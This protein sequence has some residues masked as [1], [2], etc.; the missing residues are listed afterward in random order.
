MRSQHQLC[1]Q[2][3]CVKV[4]LFFSLPFLCQF[5]F[6]KRYLNIDR[7][8]HAD[9]ESTF[10]PDPEL[11]FF[12]SCALHTF[13]PLWHPASV[14]GDQNEKQSKKGGEG[15][16]FRGTGGAVENRVGYASKTNR[17]ETAGQCCNNGV[18][19]SC[20]GYLATGA[21]CCQS[22]SNQNWAQERHRETAG[23]ALRGSDS[24]IVT[25]VAWRFT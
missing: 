5:H 4:N 21:T 8:G 19:L 25:N 2:C 15:E 20:D 12:I 13:A 1:I 11:I 23:L 18:H 16:G 6:H 24:C 14:A 22:H 17:A 7:C 9:P 10:S 3:C